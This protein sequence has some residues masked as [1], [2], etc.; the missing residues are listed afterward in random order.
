MKD[1]IVNKANLIQERFDIETKE[2][3][4]RQ[5]VYQRKQV[6][7]SKEEEELYVNY[8]Q[9]ATFRIHILEKR[10]NEHKKQAPI[11]Y[12]QLEAKIHAD[13]RLKSLR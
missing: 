1:H 4:R 6:H 9:D 10:L 12:S 5:N 2:L 8:C 3:E 13:P 11:K 7:I